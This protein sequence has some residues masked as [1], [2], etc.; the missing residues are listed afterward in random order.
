MKY[1]LNMG[2]S[3][4]LSHECLLGRISKPPFLKFEA[5]SIMFMQQRG[6]G[7]GPCPGLHTPGDRSSPVWTCG[8]TG[9][10]I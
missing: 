1:Y 2:F 8:K 7:E 9:V 3:G 10:P 6:S 5:C 4:S